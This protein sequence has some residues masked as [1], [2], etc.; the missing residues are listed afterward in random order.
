MGMIEIVL[1]VCALAQPNQCEEQHLQFLSS[2]SL[3]QCSMAAPPYIAQWIGDHPKWVAMRW[4]CDI[5]GK[6]ET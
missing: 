1:T 2:G 3:Q 4:R 6:R 5:P